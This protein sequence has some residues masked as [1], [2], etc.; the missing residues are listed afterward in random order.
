MSDD[1]FKMSN[2]VRDIL[3]DLSK[4]EHL[5][6][7]LIGFHMSTRTGS[8]DER[9]RVV[10]FRRDFLAS[11]LTP[12]IMSPFLKTRIQHLCI[13]TLQSRNDPTLTNS[14][15][16]VDLLR[17]LRFLKLTIESA[18]HLMHKG[19][20]PEQSVDFYKLFPDTWLL[21]ACQNL[22]FLYLSGDMRWGWYPK[23]D[24]R[25]INFPH[26][27]SLALGLFT[28]SH[29]WQLE[30]ILS[31]SGCLRR[32]RLIA[33]SV[34]AFADATPQ[35]LDGDGY[36]MRADDNSN[37]GTRRHLRF[38]G[39]WCYFFKAFA[40]A[41]PRLQLFSVADIENFHWD[42]EGGFELPVRSEESASL[43]TR[44][45]YRAYSSEEYLPFFNCNLDYPD[46]H[47]ASKHWQERQQLQHI[48]DKKALFEL[49]DVIET[50]NTARL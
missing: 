16:F 35:F 45:S 39:R 43:R 23:V 29:D 46:D 24:F 12:L 42:L 28:F 5:C 17:N 27:Q 22:K 25:H 40:N 50:R 49:F 34:L 7:L 9:E 38:E 26:L 11:V 31:H 48:E 3:Q 14:V 10:A 4:L 41:L 47:E 21:P 1:E 8:N 19:A 37:A 18:E 2:I 13:S 6:S 32:L 44:S 15:G 36:R 30:W 20:L 33:C